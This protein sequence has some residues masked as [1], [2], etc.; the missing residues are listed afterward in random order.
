MR[1][2]KR[3]AKA[4]GEINWPALPHSQRPG[5]I[6][7]AMVGPRQKT[8]LDL[9][10]PSSPHSPDCAVSAFP[11]IHSGGGGSLFR[12]QPPQPIDFFSSSSRLSN[13]RFTSPSLTTAVLALSLLACSVDLLS[14]LLSPLPHPQSHI[15][16]FSWSALLQTTASFHG[17]ATFFLSVGPMEPRASRRIP[18]S[19]WLFLSWA[20]GVLCAQNRVNRHD[21]L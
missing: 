16:F 19:P 2:D 17:T 11:S 20:S 5:S 14:Y 10:L 15:F 3:P 9:S 4:H 13:L 6:V 7:G 8:S 21:S 1:N 18:E 12:P